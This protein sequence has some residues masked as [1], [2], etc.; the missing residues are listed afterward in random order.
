MENNFHMR[1]YGL[2]HLDGVAGQEFWWIGG[3]TE[4]QQYVV[5]NVDGFL[6]ISG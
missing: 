6:C 5:W 1:I 2:L 3:E 4:S